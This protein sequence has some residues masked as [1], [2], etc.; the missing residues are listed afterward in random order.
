MKRTPPDKQ[1]DAEFTIEIVAILSDRE[2]PISRHAY[3][4][5]ISPK[6][7][8]SVPVTHFKSERILNSLEAGFCRGRR[9]ARSGT[10][11]TAIV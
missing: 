8:S 4:N 2:G 7:K 5:I 1:A 9:L 10:H 6:L 11:G 3:F